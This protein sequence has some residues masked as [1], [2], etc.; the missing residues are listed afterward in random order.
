[1]NLEGEH[2]WLEEDSS[3]LEEEIHCGKCMGLGHTAGFAR[4]QFK[5]RMV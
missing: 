1:M 5:H 4:V 3:G 2:H